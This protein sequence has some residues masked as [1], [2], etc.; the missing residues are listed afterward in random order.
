MALIEDVTSGAKSVDT[1]TTAGETGSTQAAAEA[2]SEKLAHQEANS[3]ATNPTL[4]HNNA[5]INP[6]GKSG[7]PSPQAP[8][9]CTTV[10]KPGDTYWGLAQ[11]YHTTPQAIEHLN[12][13]TK[14]RLIQIGQTINL[15]GRVCQ[16]TSYPS[17]PRSQRVVRPSAE[18]GQRCS[19]G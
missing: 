2:F 19:P 8:A 18:N 12:P 5:A 4:Q 15:P 9:A 3:S 17:G 7:E 11:K 13:K 14:P 6:Q 1:G 10:A 16:P